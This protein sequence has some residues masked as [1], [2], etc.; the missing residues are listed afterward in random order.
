MQFLILLTIMLGFSPPI[1]GFSPSV[2]DEII[3]KRN[4]SQLFT[5]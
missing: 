3:S 5:D 4:Y 1:F 2:P